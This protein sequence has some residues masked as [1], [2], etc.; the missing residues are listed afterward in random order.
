MSKKVGFMTTGSSPYPH[1]T[2][3]NK[4]KGKGKF[5]I[6]VVG[7]LVNTNKKAVFPSPADYYKID[8]N[9]G[10][11]PEFLIPMDRVLDQGR[12]NKFTSCVKRLFDIYEEVVNEQVEKRIKKKERLLSKYRGNTFTGG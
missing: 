7:K 9:G 11:E 4:P 12:I 1:L 6:A 8:L 10:P 3:C 5:K 2:F